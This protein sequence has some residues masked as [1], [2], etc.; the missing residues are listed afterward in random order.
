MSMSDANKRAK[1]DAWVNTAIL[2]GAIG[3]ATV[4]SLYAQKR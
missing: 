1:K 3:A 4:A 2:G